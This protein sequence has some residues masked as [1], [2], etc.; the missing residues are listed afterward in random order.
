[1]SLSGT[2]AY[3][4]DV[5][6]NPADYTSL[7]FDILWATNNSVPVAQFNASPGDQNFFMGF[8]GTFPSAGAAPNWGGDQISYISPGPVLAGAG[9]WEHISIPIEQTRPG[10][11]GLAFKKWTP[12]SANPPEP[13]TNTLNGTVTVWLDNIKLIGST[14]PP[15]PPSLTVRKSDTTG[16]QITAS[17]GNQYQRQSIA[18]T[19]AEA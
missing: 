19:S 6:A 10:F 14:A 17:G 13:N 15:P 2:G 11:A 3:N 5:V 1:M 4:G 9:T 7:E 18:A 12:G 8:A 16:V